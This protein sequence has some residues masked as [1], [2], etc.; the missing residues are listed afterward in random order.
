MPAIPGFVHFLNFEDKSDV[1]GNWSDLRH[2][3]VSSENRRKRSLVPYSFFHTR[4][5]KSSLDPCHRGKKTAGAFS[6]VARKEHLC[7]LIT[8]SAGYLCRWIHRRI[9]FVKCA[10]YKCG[11]HNPFMCIWARH[12]TFPSVLKVLQRALPYLN[13]I[14]LIKYLISKPL[15]LPWFI[16]IFLLFI[17]VLNKLFDTLW[18]KGRFC[19]QRHIGR[20][21]TAIL[22]FSS[23]VNSHSN[24]FKIKGRRSSIS[25]S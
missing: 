2:L 6:P 21:Q 14:T 23:F 25:A 4:S 3:P 22:A 11:S 12:R 19:P 10:Q 15:K 1:A 20:E 5:K 24:T 13:I 17:R 16:N 7:V 8:E 18:N 9:V